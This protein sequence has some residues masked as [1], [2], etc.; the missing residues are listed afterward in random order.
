MCLPLADLQVVVMLKSSASL[1]VE[2]EIYY[3]YSLLQIFSASS[4]PYF[5]NASTTLTTVT[6]P[7]YLLGRDD[8]KIKAQI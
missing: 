7:V 6:L 3:L 8:R 1:N 2:P 4:N 5:V